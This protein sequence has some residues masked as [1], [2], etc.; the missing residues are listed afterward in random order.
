VFEVM[1]NTVKEH[2]LIAYGDRI[3]IGLSGGPDSLAM[4][5]A[6]LELK[7]AYG[8][9]LYAVH[10]NHMFRGEHAD[11]DE[12]FVASFCIANAL[13]CYSFKVDV[14]SQAK[15]MGLS[16]EDAGRRVRY[17][18]F[19]QVMQQVGANKIAVAQNKN[20]VVETFFI[21]L[22]RG[23][24]ID[25]LA[26]IEYMRD[27]LYIR[28]LLDVSRQ[29]I[30][31]YC[32]QNDLTPRHD[33]TNDESDY[34][35]NKIRNEFLPYIRAE[36]NPS[37]DAAISKTVHIMKSDKTFWKVHRQR[38]FEAI[39]KWVEGDIQIN[40]EAFDAL[41][42]SEKYQLLRQCIL[43]MKGNL[44]D[45]SFD[46]LSRIIALHR[47]GA[48]CEIEKDLSVV[49]QY[50]V[51]LI[52]KHKLVKPIEAQTLFTKCIKRQ[53]LFKY[54][55]NQSCVAIDYDTV[56]GCLNIRTRKE[57]DFFKPLGMK[58]HKKLK[59]FFI[60]AKVPKNERSRV[61][62]VCDDEKIIWIQNMRLDERCKITETTTNIMILSFQELVERDLLC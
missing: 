61:L 19:E 46:T 49:K 36:F 2:N 31:L 7:E 29:D 8:L 50:G 40:Q 6:L 60:D 37:I 41:H 32:E 20:D 62:I 9:D 22:F 17:E 12:A 25:G 26:S 44:T 35:R 16:F 58:G 1:L 51:L 52:Y 13:P 10:V 33:G 55:I 23:A 14:P 30:E 21:N 38:L 42:E 27:Q 57:G 39:C 47:T 3:V 34:V 53:E 18:K 59:D 5:H 24:G 48:I 28:P 56:V 15:T 45:I 43:Y 11:D 4:T 54:V